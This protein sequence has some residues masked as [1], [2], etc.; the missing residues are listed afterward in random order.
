M[1]SIGDYMAAV[2]QW[3]R[4]T[5][6]PEFSLWL[7]EQPVSAL[8]A[9]NFWVIPILQT[10]HI[11]T[12]AALFGSVV[13][14]SLRIFA[15]AG[16][17]RTMSQT[18]RRYLPWVWWGLL[19]LL[20]TGIGMCIGEPTRELINPAFWTKM[21]LVLV[22]V[23]LSLWFQASVIRNVAQWETTHQR[24]VAIRVAAAGVIVLWC[25]IM[26]LGRW[27]AYAPT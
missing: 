16:R 4:S 6:L 23:L 14:I 12:V 7:Q 13:M 10:I 1:P 24:R 18:V 5:Q 11:L 25:A 26:A 20:I 8:I 17:S 3:L 27:I 21:V 2:A 22:A 9:N 15:L 19:V